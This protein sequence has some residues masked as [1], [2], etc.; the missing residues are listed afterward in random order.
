MSAWEAI[1]ETDDWYTPRYI[2]DA[3]GVGFDLDVAAPIQGPRYVPAASWLWEKGLETPW[4]G[5][6]W[7][8]PPY[9]GRNALLPWVRKFLDHGDGVA[10]VPDRTSAPWFQP[11][12]CEADAILFVR[13][14]IKFERPDGSLGVSPGS[15]SAL[16]ARGERGVAALL[17]ASANNLGFVLRGERVVTGE[18]A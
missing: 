9:G 3:M 12:G 6:I 18:V 15:G 4:S 14:K 13:R 5:F 8:N 1:G 11:I 2:F 10:L 17:A 7:M 16:V